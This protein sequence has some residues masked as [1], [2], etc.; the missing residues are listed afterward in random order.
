MVGYLLLCWLLAANLLSGPLEGSDWPNTLAFAD[1][2]A[3]A[4]PAIPFWFPYQGGGVSPSAGYAIGPIY[5]V[6]ALHRAGL[7]LVV[8]G[9]VLAFIAMAGGALGVAALARSVGLGRG[10]SFAA[11]AFALLPP[12]AWNLL[13][14]VGF[15]P[16]TVAAALLPWAMAALIAYVRYEGPRLDRRGV[17][18]FA[19]SA[20]LLCATFLAHPAVAPSAMVLGAIVATTL[21]RRGLGRVVAAGVPALLC[22]SGGLVSFVLYNRAASADGTNDLTAAIVAGQNIPPAVLLGVSEKVPTSG[23]LESMSLTPFLLVL[24]AIAVPFALRERRWRG[25]LVTTAFTLVYL[26]SVDVEIA[27]ATAVPLVSPLLGF[28]GFLIFAIIGLAVLSAAGLA[29]LARLA[30]R[31][32]TPVLAIPATVLVAL[33]AL[34]FLEIPGYGPR[35]QLDPTFL[36]GRLPEM[37]ARG[38]M[39]VQNGRKLPSG[40]SSEIMRDNALPVVA[41]RLSGLP[42]RADVSPR[43]GSVLKALPLTSDARTMNLYTFTLSLLHLSWS[44]EQQALFLENAY[45]VAGA[46]VDE[47]SAWFG[48]DRVAFDARD[49]GLPPEDP[50]RFRAAGWKVTD[51]G[52]VTLADA[53]RQRMLAAFRARGVLLHIGQTK[54]ETYRNT[55]RLASAGAL[56][57][58]DGW[59]V[60]GPACVDDISADELARFDVVVLE[61]QCERDGAASDAKLSAYVQRGGR[62]FI[63]T[64]WEFSRFASTP[65]L[66]DFLPVTDLRWQSLGVTPKLAFG[67]SEVSVRGLDLARFG[68]FRFASATWD[69]S[70]PSSSLRE[71]SRA[72]VLA[73][74]RPVVAAGHLG[75][76]R[77]AWS[78]MNLV[79][80]ARAKQSADEREL[81]H[82]VMQWLLEGVTASPRELALERQSEDGASVRLPADGW[83]LWREPP[84]Y[85]TLAPEASARYSAGPGLLLVR[86]KAGEVRV[87][88]HPS[89]TMRGATILGGISTLGLLLWLVLRLARGGMGD[90]AGVF[91]AT[92]RAVR[93]AATGWMGNEDA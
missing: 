51:A 54:N 11:G 10:W 12:A 18:L 87:E 90:P 9:R 88:Q 16:N 72:V 66:P 33:L 57:F 60:Q 83:L 85:A 59:L 37:V 7:D 73:D 89:A 61:D 6:A 50:A 68:D 5:A 82:R 30:S 93:G 3:R 40:I 17:A 27:L 70:A 21:A 20:L 2:V 14:Y 77:V 65:Q 80:H 91:G 78:G 1:W 64:G 26:F 25:L 55:Y 29:S 49:P 76:G 62:L 48:L 69:V 19:A 8:A 35:H 41:E 74:G 38:Q 23:L 75:A 45:G 24:A 58:E 81:Y 34:V 15:F 22:A 56:P 31:L 43:L 86:M 63:E 84:Q 52:E 53:S 32:V 92:G 67:D 79:T 39:I 71:W 36:R 13:V 28:R 42:G 46:S 4:F 47:M 44:D